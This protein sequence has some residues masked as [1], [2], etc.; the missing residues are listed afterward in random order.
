[1]RCGND[2]LLIQSYGF[3]LAPQNNLPARA[4]YIG[5]MGGIVSSLVAPSLHPTHRRLTLLIIARTE[6]RHT[7]LEKSQL[8]KQPLLAELFFRYK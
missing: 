6:K 4:A 1:M 3:L 5:S 2:F 7:R 8:L